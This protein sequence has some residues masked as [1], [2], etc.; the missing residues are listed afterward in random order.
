MKKSIM[1]LQDKFEEILP[2]VEQKDK[3]MNNRGEIIYIT[4]PRGLTCCK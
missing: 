2:K 1:K 3:E 4:N